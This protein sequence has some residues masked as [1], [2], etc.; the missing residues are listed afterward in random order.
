MFHVTIFDICQ[1]TVCSG[2]PGMSQDGPSHLMA[3]LHL[4]PRNSPPHC[5]EAL[6]IIHFHRKASE[7]AWNSSCWSA[8]EPSSKHTN[9]ETQTEPGDG[10]ERRPGPPQPRRVLVPGGQGHRLDGTDGPRPRRAGQ[11]AGEVTNCDIDLTNIV[12]LS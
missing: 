12:N 1:L 11:P 9:L 10:G 6:R 3:A 8:D 2:R 5:T 4:D 7:S